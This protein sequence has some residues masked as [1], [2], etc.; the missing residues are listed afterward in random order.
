ML[1]GSR[2]T[3]GLGKRA[4]HAAVIGALSIS[5]MLGGCGIVARQASSIADYNLHAGQIGRYG[6]LTEQEMQWAKT[7]WRYFENNTNPDNGLVNSFDRYPT[8]SMWHVADYM[9]ALAAAR[10]LAVIDAREFD[11]RMSRLLKFLNSMDLSEGSVPNKLYNSIT[12]KMVNYANQ[13]E[14]IGW[15][16]VETGRLL[17]WMK[18]IGV[19][20]PQY[21]EYMDKA[22]LRW[23]FCQVID[24]C[25]TMYGASRSNG[26]RQ[27]YQEGRLG[28]EQAGAAGFAAWGFDASRIWRA[29]RVETVTILGVPVQHDARDPRTTGAP[30]AVM[31]M[32]HVLLGM[33]YGWRYP[34]DAGAAGGVDLRQLAE[35]VYRVQETRYRREGIL[36]ART[37]YQIREAPYAVTDTVFAAGYPWNTLGADG[38]EYEKLALVST[39]AAF[40]MWVLW[41]GD[42][43]DRLMQSVQTLRN[44]ERG[45]YEG[46]LENSGA[47]L[48]T[49]SLSTNAMVLETLLFKVR[50]QLYPGEAAPGYFERRLS[51]PFE[52]TVQCLPQ[53]RA[54]CKPGEGV[55]Q[56]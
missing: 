3:T 55:A 6:K 26:Q 50:G 31:T 14:D 13:P 32:P 44:P 15:S 41:P 24:D 34:G 52:R 25:G 36:T 48:E 2:R 23:N 20:Y 53:E 17:T 56:R 37:D 35:Q 46:R 33:E 54:M 1:S 21:R 39:R 9:A 43:T 27:R 28:Y 10:D 45:W 7:A 51:D 12:G 42:Y 4:A 18:I 49:I 40:G 38:K 16:A 8:F 29:P 47:A 11:Y 5:M 30:N 19:R 22:V